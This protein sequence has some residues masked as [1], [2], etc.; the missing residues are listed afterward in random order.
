MNM[1]LEIPDKSFRIDS[2]LHW[3]NIKMKIRVY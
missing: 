3:E 1:I 2:H